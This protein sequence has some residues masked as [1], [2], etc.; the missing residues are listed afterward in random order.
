MDKCNAS[1]PIPPMERTKEVPSGMSTCLLWEKP[2]GKGEGEGHGKGKGQFKEECVCGALCKKM[3]HIS[4]SY[5]IDTLESIRHISTARARTVLCVLLIS[6]TG[7]CT[8]RL[9]G[10]IVLGLVIA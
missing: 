7:S 3:G 1:G 5:L 8:G 4:T 2:T 9:M 6:S 10:H